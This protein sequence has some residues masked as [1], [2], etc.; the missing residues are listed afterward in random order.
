M[1]RSKPFDNCFNINLKPD[2]ELLAPCSVY[3][4]AFHIMFYLPTSENV[5]ELRRVSR[6]YLLVYILM[7]GQIYPCKSFSLPTSKNFEG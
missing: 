2:S 5:I 7:G 4:S 3:L 6:I 1:K